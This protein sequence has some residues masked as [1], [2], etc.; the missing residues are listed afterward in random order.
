[1]SGQAQRQLEMDAEVL[2][3]VGADAVSVRLTRPSDRENLQAYVGSLSLDSRYNRFLGVLRKLPD[4]EM[5]RV[6]HH[7]SCDRLSLVVTKLVDGSETIIGE[8]RYGRHRDVEA[9]ELALSIGDPWQHSGIG[10]A[11]IRNLEQRAQACGA[12]R[13]Y[14]DVWA[15]NRRMIAL[16]LK[17]GY[18]ATASP[19]GWTQA[20]YQKALRDGEP[21]S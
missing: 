6:L 14:G 1:M 11:L 5:E 15:S 2:C 19:G 16:A 7:T 18:S 9:V 21:T 3:Q 12:E 13:V 20:R 17:A 8:A 4:A 10:R